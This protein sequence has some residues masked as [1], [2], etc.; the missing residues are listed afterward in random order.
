[1]TLYKTARKQKHASRS[2]QFLRMMI[3]A[4]RRERRKEGGGRGGGGG[5][6]ETGGRPES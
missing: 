5:R 1:M 2:F 3:G 6:R 4:G